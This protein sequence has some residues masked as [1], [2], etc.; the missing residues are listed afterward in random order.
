MKCQSQRGDVLKIGLQMIEQSING[1]LFFRGGRGVHACVAYD[2]TEISA[3]MYSDGLGLLPIDFLVTFDN[4]QT[5]GKCQ[6]AWRR[7]DHIGAV[8]ERWVDVRSGVAV[9][10]SDPA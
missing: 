5:I 9:S 8:F 7:R 1:L 6:L 2:V 10:N 4:F 3:R